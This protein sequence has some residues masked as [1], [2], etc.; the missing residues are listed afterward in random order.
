MQ[1]LFLRF[2][3]TLCYLSQSLNCT[4]DEV[5]YT[6][7]IIITGAVTSLLVTNLNLLFRL[8]KHLKEISLLILVDSNGDGRNVS[9]VVE[10]SHLLR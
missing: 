9:G 2:F 4:D 5:Y 7:Y 6:I 1:I 3:F 10:N 8:A